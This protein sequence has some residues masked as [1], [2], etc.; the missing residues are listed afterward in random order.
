MD[1]WREQTERDRAVLEVV[2]QSRFPGRDE[3]TSQLIGALVASDCGCGCGSFKPEPRANF[4]SVPV[5]GPVGDI[6]GRDDAG[7]L[8]GLFV[9]VTGGRVQ[10]VEC[11]GLE[12]DPVSL[13]RPESLGE[14]V[15]VTFLS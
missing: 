6:Y 14:T 9:L 4:L 2:L 10:Y 15:R 3:I 8:V 13:P 5:E 11:Y 12:C 7:N 1:E